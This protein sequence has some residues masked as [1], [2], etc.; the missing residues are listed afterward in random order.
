MKIEIKMELELWYLH[1]WF[2]IVYKFF[3]GEESGFIY[4][5][6]QVYQYSYSDW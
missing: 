5:K 2:E 1:K 3:G 6:S 4:L